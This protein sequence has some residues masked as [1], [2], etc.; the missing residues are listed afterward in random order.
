MVSAGVIYTV[1][2]FK[3]SAVMPVPSQ[4]LPL[5]RDLIAWEISASL[6]MLKGTGSGW[7]DEKKL[8]NVVTSFT[9]IS[10]LDSK[11]VYFRR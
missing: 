1:A 11:I 3:C 10:L 6:N 2:Y 5:F 4:A 9:A 7:Y 8:D